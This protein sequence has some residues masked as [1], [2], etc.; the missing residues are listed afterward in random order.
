MATARRAAGDVASVDGEWSRPSVAARLSQTLDSWR[1]GCS[2]SPW[3]WTSDSTPNTESQPVELSIT[4]ILEYLCHSQ[5]SFLSSS[6]I[7]SFL[8]YSRFLTSFL[9][10]SVPLC[11]Q[12]PVW[13]QHSH[14]H[15]PIHVALA[16]FFSLLLVYLSIISCKSHF[17]HLFFLQSAWQLFLQCSDTVG[18][19]AG[20]T[21]GL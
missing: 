8:L 4:V 2:C 7:S 12:L 11:L 20:R 16:F 19:V 21:S 3:W 14:R 13:V 5:N 15:L 6:V 18:W 17:S 1:S 10:V 9:C